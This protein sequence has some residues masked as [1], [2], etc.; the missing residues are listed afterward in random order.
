MSDLQKFLVLMLVVLVVSVLGR[1][2]WG[3][4]VPPFTALIGAVP[5]LV[6]AVPG[7]L[8]WVVF[9]VAMSM[10]CPLKIAL[11]GR[12]CGKSSGCARDRSFGSA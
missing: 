11:F 10:I 12:G 1:L 6:A 9:G 4:I 5:S 7:W 3:M 2:A 8:W